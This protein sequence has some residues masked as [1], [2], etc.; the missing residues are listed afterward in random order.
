MVGRT[1]FEDRFE[2]KEL[3]EKPAAMRSEISTG[4]TRTNTDASST[5]I[6]SATTE[7]SNDIKESLIGQKLV[8]KT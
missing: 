5:R 7:I 6:P 2:Q 8:A 4:R 3:P 1:L